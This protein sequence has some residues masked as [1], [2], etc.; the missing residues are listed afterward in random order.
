MPTPRVMDLKKMS[1]VDSRE[2]Y[3][4]IYKQLIGSFM[5]PINTRPDIC[6]AMNVL[7]QFMS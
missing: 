2:I 5:Y 3:P 7:N 6:Y 1:D 4:H